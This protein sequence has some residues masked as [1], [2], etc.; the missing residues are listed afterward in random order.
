MSFDS[1]VADGVLQVARQQTRWLS[2]GWNGG[3][4]EAPAAYN[5][6][7]PDGWT[8]TDVSDYLRERRT[9]AGF[10]RA[11][12]G[13]LTGVEMRHARGAR[14]DAVVA[15]ATV[16]LSNP[17]V[18]PVESDCGDGESRDRWSTDDGESRDQSPTDE[19]RSGDSPPSDGHV[20]TVNVIVCTTRQLTDAAAA[21]LLAVAVEAKTTT[22]L[23]LAGFPGTT[24]DAVIVGSAS[25]H[26]AASETT[27][28]TDEAT[29][30]TT[31][32]EST[33]TT[34]DAATVFSGSATDVGS[35]ARACVRDAVRASF[36]S[37]YASTDVPAT[38]A[39]AD[40]G[41][42]TDE[43]ATVFEL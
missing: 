38:V 23:S 35:A 32:S 40:H 33:D 7:V 22:L 17:A 6:T 41:V 34:D 2:T 29:T 9:R 5:V 14:R 3:F 25:G 39:D 12:P 31:D 11:G 27:H 13:L 20:G 36:Q 30:R 16:G 1:T 28:T 42:V 10:E 15:Y 24:S 43:R 19:G 18:L 8:R 26:A 37:R 21:N 4:R